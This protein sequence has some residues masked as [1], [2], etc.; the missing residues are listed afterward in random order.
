M[1]LIAYLVNKKKKIKAKYHLA[2]KIFEAKYELIHQKVKSRFDIESTE[3]D[4][5]RYNINNLITQSKESIEYKINSIRLMPNFSRTSIKN[6]DNCFP[7]I[8][9]WFYGRFSGQTIR[10]IV[11]EGKIIEKVFMSPK[12]NKISVKRSKLDFL[13]RSIPTMQIKLRLCIRS[14]PI[15]QIKPKLFKINQSGCPRFNLYRSI[16]T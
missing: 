7:G 3:P 15:M 8:I 4:L 13:I 2:K 5:I 1:A 9:D 14:K 16:H 11:R 10:L 6:N 12:G